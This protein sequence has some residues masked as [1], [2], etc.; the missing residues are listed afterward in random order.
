M[1]LAPRAT[2]LTAAWQPLGPASVLSANYGKVSGRVTAAAFDSSD[3][4]GN[5]LYIGTTGGGVWKSTNAAGP[6]SSVSFTPLTDTLPVFNA[7]SAS[8]TV[9]SLSI[10]ALAV[11]PVSNGIVLAGTGDPNDATDSYYGEGILRST[12]GGLTWSQITTSHDG[13]NGNH[14][15][16]GL[17]VAGLAWSTAS[18]SLVVAALSTS[19]EGTLVGASDST[20]VRG[21]YYST[22][23]GQTWH[24]ASI[25]DG[26]QIV[27]V[28]QP[29]GS[30]NPGNAVTDVVWNPQRQRFY[31]AVRFHGFYESADGI[32]WKRLASEPGTGLTAAN[33]PSSTAAATCPIFRGVLAVQPATSDTY[34]LSVDSA[35][36]DNGL[37]QDQCQ[38]TGTAC[39]TISPT[40]QKRIDG[41]ALETIPGSTVVP[42]GDYNLSLAAAPSATGTVLFA[43]TVD[44]YR[45]AIATG[46]SSCSLRNTTNALNG[47]NSSAQV[48]PAQHAL[49]V[50]AQS[51]GAPL[52]YSGNDGGLWRSLDG[53]AQTGPACSATDAQHFDNLNGALGSL[54]EV[55]GFAQHPSDAD[56]LIAGLGAN[57]TASTTSATASWS[58]RTAWQQLSAGEGG[59][60]SID[61]VQPQN[62]Y[63]ATGAHISLSHCSLGNA[64]TAADF[65]GATPTIGAPQVSGDSALIDAPTLL[66]PQQT[67]N[68]VLGTC[69]VWRGPAADGSVWSAANAISAPFGSTALPCGSSNSYVRSLAAGGPFASSGTPAHSGSTVLYAG[70]AGQMDGGGAIG[71]HLFTTNAANVTSGSSQWTDASAGSVTNDVAN[72]HVFN[73]I[74][75]D[76]SSVAV[77]SHDPS[78]ATVYATIMGFGTETTASPH[79][80]RSTDFGA[81]WLNVSANLP[82]A[83]ANAL[84]I[85]PNDANTVYIALDAG[86]Y[87]TTQITTCSTTN[88]WSLLGTG[89]P[90]APVTALSA[91]ANL[92]TG[93]GRI[94]MLRAGTYGRGL[95]QI[96]LLT[97]ASAAKPAL[98]LSPTSLSFAAQPTGTQS[99]AQTIIVSSSGNSPATI[100]S[101]S[102]SA[103]F[104]ESDTCTG[105]TLSVGS[106][107][108]IQV[109]FAPTATGTRSG[110]LTIYANVAGGQV[111]APLSGSATAPA[112]VVLTP[113]ALTFPA[114]LVNQTSATQIIT[115][116]NTGGATV[117]LQ[118]PV[119]TGDFALKANTCGATLAPSTGCS[120]SIAF[121]P[122]ASGTR[123]GILSITDDAGTQTAALTGSGTSPAT[124]T[125]SPLTLAF[126]PQQIGSSSAAQQVIL[127]NSGDAPLTLISS[128]I[129][130]GPFTQT[131]TCGTSLS[132]HSSCA[133]SVSFVPVATGPASGTLT[134]S[135]QFRTQTV[136]LSGT[137]QAPAGV[138]IT[139][140]AGLAFGA[141]GVATTSPSQ[142]LVLTNNG[143]T[144][145][146]ISAVSVSGDFQLASTTCGATLNATASCIFV[147]TFTPSTTGARTGALTLTDNA[148]SG[149]QSVPLSGTGFDFT[150]AHDGPTSATISSGASATYALL[151]S[152]PAGVSG[153]AQ[154]ACTGAPVHALCTV[155]PASAPLG[156]MPVVITV[157]VSTGLAQ[158]HV[159]P[160]RFET[161]AGIAL[162]LAAPILFVRR[163]HLRALALGL[164][165]LAIGAFT[166]GC[167]AGR[168]LPASGGGSPTSTP[169]PSGTYTLTVSATSNGVLRS[170]PLALTVQ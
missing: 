138:S 86:V 38:S 35:N 166:G 109:S 63:I 135:D 97:A 95:W 37:W 162:A 20:A 17:S 15:F 49:S 126:A 76:V 84:V 123:N 117:A 127:T 33:C 141:V 68:V 67:S 134:V 73:P 62:W 6:L 8:V 143:G 47:C 59:Q 51:T 144:A 66:D 155:S 105:Q 98:N 156:T 147:V 169:T 7:S 29:T 160:L 133:L 40:W 45:C 41:A 89:L 132:A 10:G 128:S 114:T 164:A 14:S 165:V 107:C 75:F 11:Q 79:V 142:A 90:N 58:A 150:L 103:D 60:P 9:P 87:V 23:A 71:G 146:T 151:L 55:V 34:A 113:G 104:V 78:G 50:M 48:A 74:G 61:A 21:L 24:M 131:S 119:L 18:P 13:A 30:A 121:T 85:D 22:D 157:T 82:D 140:V 96:P 116:S 57:G 27:Q 36:R 112:A 3:T 26:A 108:S 118:Q 12:D 102:V 153:T 130:S 91:G 158:A 124:D 54:A 52:L 154:L 69:R 111:T 129:T 4:T 170:V 122:T 81:H 65:A 101:V 159:S 16:L 92:P 125:L 53:V 100:S 19:A 93:D 1:L 115:V 39:A 145:L 161:G 25:Y 28:P 83:P 5:T 80:Y 64:C 163:R 46:T 42:Q 94:G 149:T 139:P 99:P 167:G 106:T 32:L 70:L 148:A 43:G 56:V 110:L 152:A 72:A 168:Q 136:T 137:G 77:D 88:C 31:A 44:L 2:S 120:L